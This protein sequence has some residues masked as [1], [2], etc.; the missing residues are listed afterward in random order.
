MHNGHLLV[1][2][3]KMSKSL[4]NVITVHGAIEEASP[5]LVRLGLLSSHYRQPLDWDRRTVYDT[6][7]SIMDKWCNILEKS[8]DFNPP[9]RDQLPD[10]IDCIP[11]NVELALA[12]DLNVPL[13][14][15]A[16]H[17][18]ANDG[19]AMALYQ[20]A[21][22]LGL[23]LLSFSG[24]GAVVISAQHK[25]KIE[26]LIQKRQE[27]RENKDFSLSDLIRDGMH[28]CGID[29]EDGKTGS[30]WKNQDRVNWEDFDLFFWRVMQQQDTS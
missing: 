19:D 22:I 3:E 7:K 29:I 12:D 1:D 28:H 27:A 30:V 24:R 17:K 26:S 8:S 16:L 25:E 2:G 6:G 18:Y 23:D 15:T 20:G 13:A 11:D 5:A 4:G 9:S 10:V 21:S 14:I